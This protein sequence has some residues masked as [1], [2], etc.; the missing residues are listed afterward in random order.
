MSN[1][2]R[3]EKK[4]IEAARAMIEE[5]NIDVNDMTET[6]DSLLYMQSLYL[7]S[8]DSSLDELKDI[9]N[10]YGHQLDSEKM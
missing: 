10:A 1:H 7:D 4:S 2:I 8:F 6:L 3:I 9:A 5:K